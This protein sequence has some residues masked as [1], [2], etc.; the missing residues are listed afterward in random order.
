VSRRTATIPASYFDALYAANPDP[1]NFA[2]SPYE[3]QKYDATIAAMPRQRYDRGLEVGCS[4]GILTRR[5]AARCRRLL[6][7]DA[8]Q[9]PLVEARRSCAD[10]PNVTFE[11]RSIPE[12]WPDGEFDLIVLSEVI[13]YLTESAV[14]AAASRAVK[15]LSPGGDIVLVHWIG[16]TD[17]PLS[18]DDAAQ[19]FIRSARAH[20]RLVAQERTL[21]YRLDVLQGS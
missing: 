3:I 14:A 12:E 4:I 11:R 17:Y 21:R 8:S 7:V 18:G 9:A 20:A 6:A 15:S 5:L 13:Y 19:H 10:H 16:E 2:S 1:W